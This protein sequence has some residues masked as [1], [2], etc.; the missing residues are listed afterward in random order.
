LGR[1]LV[2]SERVGNNQGKCLTP[3]STSYG[4]NSSEVHGEFKVQH[5]TKILKLEDFVDRVTV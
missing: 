1:V 3:G 2:I 4:F 5:K